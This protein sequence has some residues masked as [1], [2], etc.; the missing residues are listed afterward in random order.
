MQCGELS[1]LSGL[2]WTTSSQPAESHS[3]DGG[4]YYSALPLPPGKFLR[5]NSCAHSLSFFFLALHLPLREDAAPSCLSEKCKM[6]FLELQDLHLASGM[7][8]SHLGELAGHCR[9]FCC[10]PKAGILTLLCLHPPGCSD[11]VPVPV[12][13]REGLEGPM[14]QG[15]LQ[16]FRVTEPKG[17]T[18]KVLLLHCQPQGSCWHCACLPS[19][20]YRSSRLPCRTP[21]CRLASAYAF[22]TAATLAATFVLQMHPDEF[23]FNEGLAS[24]MS[25]AGFPHY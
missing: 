22:L 1:F 24:Q 6:K 12:L 9:I 23:K 19:T 2:I 5:L 20:H 13:S 25:R 11:L 18:G 17:S 15:N 3:P 8:S 21:S 7:V 4:R 16:I 10:F 14:S